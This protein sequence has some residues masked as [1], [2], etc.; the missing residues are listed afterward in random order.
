MAV[1]SADIRVVWAAAAELCAAVPYKSARNVVL[2]TPVDQAALPPPLQ[3]RKAEQE[4]D[5]EF[6]SSKRQREI[7]QWRQEQ[8][9]SGAAESNPN[10]MPLGGAKQQAEP[11]SSKASKA[12]KAAAKAAKAAKQAAAAAGDGAA[13]SSSSKGNAP[14]GVLNSRTKPDL[15]ALS[16]GLP[17]GWRAM[18]DKSSGD[19]YYGNP[20]SRV[21]MWP[22]WGCCCCSC[23]QD[24]GALLLLCSLGMHC[25]RLKR[26]SLC[27]WEMV[28]VCCLRRCTAWS[29][30]VGKAGLGTGLPWRC[31]VCTCLLAC[32]TC[33]VLGVCLLACCWLGGANATQPIS[34]GWRLGQPCPCSGAPCPLVRSGRCAHAGKC[35]Q[36]W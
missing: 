7:E 2:A 19:V 11:S 8:L 6:Q 20:G 36:L 14:S 10:F 28:Q 13:G 27:H 29:I 26:Q 16:A 22:G 18:W 31:N 5:P 34:L 1:S 4:A 30:R 25:V 32:C 21:R 15:E 12:A 35:W 17:R 3:R 9:R 24:E 33:Y 23:W